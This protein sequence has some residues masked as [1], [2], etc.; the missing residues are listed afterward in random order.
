[1]TVSSAIGDKSIPDNPLSVLPKLM[2][3]I[4][5]SYMK[6]ANLSSA[7]SDDRITTVRR[8]KV[9]RNCIVMNIL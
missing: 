7:A 2:G 1:M 8:F 4:L 9:C 6:L 3:L 5:Q